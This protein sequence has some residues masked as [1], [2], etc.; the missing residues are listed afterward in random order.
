MEKKRGIIGFQSGKKKEK[1]R[2]LITRQSMKKKG[3]ISSSRD[4]TSPIFAPS[5]T[6]LNF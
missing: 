6:L 2:F 4:A 5:S 3:K 1:I